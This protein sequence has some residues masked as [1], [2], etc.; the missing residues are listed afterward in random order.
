MTNGADFPS[1]F[2]AFNRFQV[3][4][5]NQHG[6]HSVSDINTRV[7][8]RLSTLN[9]I[10]PAGPWYPGRPVIVTANNPALQLFNGDIGI[11]LAD[12]ESDGQ[13]RVCFLRGDGSI[14]KALPARLTNCETAFAMTI[15][16]SQ[17]SEF[18]NIL[19]ML[20]DKI[21]PVLS[22]ELLYTAISRA[23]T[24]VKIAVEQG[25]FIAS[26]ARRY[27]VTAVLPINCA[28]N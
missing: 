16:K 23:K 13:L 26:I 4:C 8:Q 17:G 24:Q 27:C 18:E 3:L 15:H 28:F 11:C 5:S 10:R 21:N 9:K 25:I 12:A 1:I 7:E 6:R 14:K 22:K 20:P 19:I 2:A